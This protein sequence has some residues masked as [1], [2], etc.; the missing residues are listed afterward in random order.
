[1]CWASCPTHLFFSFFFF[2]FLASCFSLLP[3][4]FFFSLLP[5]CIG[6][7]QAKA[8]FAI[9]TT[10]LCS[11]AT[12]VVIFGKKKFS[13]PGGRATESMPSEISFRNTTY[14]LLPSHDME[15]G[16]RQQDRPGGWTSLCLARCL[17][18]QQVIS[19]LFSSS[20]LP[21]QTPRAKMKVS[22]K[23]NPPQQN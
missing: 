15:A 7:L 12:L 9:A 10:R 18:K 16:E 23:I 1:M 6:K 21:I 5:A 11:K 19:P 20:P 13:K 14:I 3:P 4:L 17:P 2:L 22:I 8:V